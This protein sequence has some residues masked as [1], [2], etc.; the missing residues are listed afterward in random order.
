MF[1]CWRFRKAHGGK[2][3]MHCPG[4]ANGIGLGSS[5]MMGCIR[6]ISRR[7]REKNTTLKLNGKGNPDGRNLGNQNLENLVYVR[8]DNKER[9]TQQVQ[10]MYIHQT[11]SEVNQKPS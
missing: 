3:A 11:Q 10:S 8:I 4:V 2:E 5:E 9:S 1:P 7:K 6:C